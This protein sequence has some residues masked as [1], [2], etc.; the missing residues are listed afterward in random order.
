V[1]E[2]QGNISITS[3]DGSKIIGIAAAGE[4]MTNKIA[5]ALPDM[6]LLRAFKF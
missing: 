4:K 6:K 2:S 5:L 1:S 3:G